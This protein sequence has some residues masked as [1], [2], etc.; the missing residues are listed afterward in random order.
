MT[1]CSRKKRWQSNQDQSFQRE[2]QSFKNSLI[3]HRRKRLVESFVCIFSN[4]RFSSQGTNTAMTW[5]HQGVQWLGGVIVRGAVKV[6]S[7]QMDED[8]FSFL[9]RTHLFSIY[10]L[11]TDQGGGGLM[12][13]L[14][15]S[16]SLTDL[17]EHQQFDQHRFTDVTEE[18][19]GVIFLM[20]SSYPSSILFHQ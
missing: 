13:Q 8:G 14:K 12:Q 6:K 4:G 5:I 9:I 17:G 11:N 1:K 15:R 3:K 16:Y 18:E 7:L 2:S 19:E 20:S 10:N